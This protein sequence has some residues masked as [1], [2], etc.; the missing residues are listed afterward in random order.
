[1]NAVISQTRPARPAS[2]LD[3]GYSG[4]G[5]R[6]TLDPQEAAKFISILSASRLVR[7]PSDLFAWLK[8][9]RAF[10]PHQVLIAAWGDFQRW[11]VKCELVWHLPGAR[12]TQ[13]RGCALDDV[14]RDAY[15]QWLRG[16]R[17]PL[18]L[19]AAAV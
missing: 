1:M 4:I 5:E 6:A 2:W 8:D 16:G 11:N 15:M 12:L 14:L 3:N 7:R 18:V 9:A 17:E 10:L 19:S 13:T